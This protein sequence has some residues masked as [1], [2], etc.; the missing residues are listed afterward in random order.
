V[1]L[2]PSGFK[3]RQ[4]SACCRAYVQVTER[5]LL[6]WATQF[7]QDILERVSEEG[8]IEPVEASDGPSCPFLRRLPRGREGAEV[9]ACTIHGAKPEACVRFPASREEAERLGCRAMR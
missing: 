8:L 3:C 4:C 1:P 9:Y 5:D 7:R 2:H 6:R